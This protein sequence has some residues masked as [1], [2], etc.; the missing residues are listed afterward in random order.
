MLIRRAEKYKFSQ[1]QRFIIE[2]AELPND[3]LNIIFNYI[4]NHNSLGFDKEYIT[5]EVKRCLEL[6]NPENEKNITYSSNLYLR[7]ILPEHRKDTLFGSDKKKILANIAYSDYA[8]KNILIANLFSLIRNNYP[9]HVISLIMKALILVVKEGFEHVLPF[10]LEYLK[11]DLILNTNESL[12]YQCVIR[13]LLVRDYEKMDS[14]L[15]NN[16]SLID[17]GLVYPLFLKIF[18]PECGWTD[19]ELYVIDSEKVTEWLNSKNIFI[20]ALQN[21]Y[22][23]Y[24]TD[25]EKEKYSDLSKVVPETD[26]TLKIPSNSIKI[27]AYQGTVNVILGHFESIVI[28]F[29][30]NEY[31]YKTGGSSNA[32]TLVIFHNNSFFEKTMEKFLPLQLKK[33]HKFYHMSAMFKNFFNYIFDILEL[34]YPIIK[35]VKREIVQERWHLPISLNELLLFHNKKEL[36]KAKYKSANEMKIDF[37]KMSFNMAYILVKTYPYVDNK[38]KGILQNIKNQ[39]LFDNLYDW[40]YR[41]NII[42]LISNYYEEKGIFDHIL[43]KDYANMCMLAGEKISLRYNSIVKLKEAHDRIAINAE[44]KGTGKVKIPKN[45]V[46]NGLRKILPEEFEWIKSRKRLMQEANMQ[47]HCVWSYAE[48]ISSD[49]CA[50]YSYLDTTGQY[51]DNWKGIPE[52]YTIEFLSNSNGYKINQI[53][54]TRNQK[55]TIKM[56]EYVSLIIN[57]DYEILYKT[58]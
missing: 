16:L 12:L 14:I 41:N 21:K 33:I 24:E 29:Y 17:E 32:L 54:G 1:S 7:N 40:K 53:Q 51:T 49:R 8:N 3:K 38:S 55:T 50:I 26:I 20:K 19:E 56:Y 13:K 37:N 23:D 46:F 27:S 35:D 25:I 42:Q 45:S 28:Q 22:P 11:K 6:Y 58:S 39:S 5:V 52:R 36:F 15:K 44:K 57:K 4:Y 47:H 31:H 30:N 9:K 2:K 43:V 34:E 48:R 10:D 18:K